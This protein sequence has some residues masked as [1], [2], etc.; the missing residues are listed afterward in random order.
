MSRW[1]VLTFINPKKI[2]IQSLKDSL[3]KKERVYV[4]GQS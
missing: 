2:L 1:D 3:L 4:L